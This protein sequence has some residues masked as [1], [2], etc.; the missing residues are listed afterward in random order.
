MSDDNQFVISRQH[1]FDL[2]QSIITEPLE[3]TWGMRLISRYLHRI[4]TWPLARDNHQNSFPVCAG[5]LKQMQPR[6]LKKEK[7]NDQLC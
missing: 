6:M 3:S 4:V 1:S 2:G 5:N 7:K